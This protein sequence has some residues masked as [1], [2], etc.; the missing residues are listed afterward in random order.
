MKRAKNISRPV[1]ED[2]MGV[3]GQG[4]S[5]GHKRLVRSQWQNFN[6]VT[7]FCAYK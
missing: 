1:D 3:F 6:S 7:I 2:D 4:S 5:S